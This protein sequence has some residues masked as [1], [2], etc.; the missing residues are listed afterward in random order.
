[1]EKKQ[2][3][4]IRL[5]E[6]RKD[7]GKTQGKFGESLG[8]TQGGYSDLERGKNNLTARIKY[9]LEEIYNIN[10][11]YLETGQGE[12]YRPI[13]SEELAPG[14]DAEKFYRDQNQR[15]IFQLQKELELTKKENEYLHKIVSAKDEVIS[16]LKSGKPKGEDEPKS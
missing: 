4:G 6:Y 5:R 13:E 14:D 12:R 11:D 8:L 10:I 7:S 9:M 2:Q 3:I 1:M 15:I 16:A